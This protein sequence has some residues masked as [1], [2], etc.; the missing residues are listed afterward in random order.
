MRPVLSDVKHAE[1]REIK[2]YLLA[3]LERAREVL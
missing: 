1:Y 3:A 2:T